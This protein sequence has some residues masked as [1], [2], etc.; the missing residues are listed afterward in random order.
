MDTTGSRLIVFCGKGG[1]GKTT[2]SLAL[3]LHHADCGRKTVVVT[4]HPLPELAVTISLQGLKEQYPI[5]AQNL[6]VV[7]VDAREELANKVRQQIPSAFLARAVLSS[8]I[9]QSLVEVAP[10]LKELSFLAR[11]RQ[12]AERRTDE[13]TADF[14]VLIWDAPAT[15]HFI[16]MLKVARD[17][18]TYLSG[19][20]ALAGRELFQ[21]LATRGNVRLF[22]VTTLEEMAVEETIELC[23]QL[24]GE[25]NLQPAGVICNLASPLLNSPDGDH[26]ELR[27]R[28]LEGNQ[29]S[30][31]LRFIFDRICIERALFR[32]LRAA[33]GVALH[34]VERL[35]GWSS[36]LELLMALAGGAGRSLETSCR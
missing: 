15:G 3:G 27:C 2:L 11:L 22:P 20:F 14:D 31:D 33:I 9:Y 28:M 32:R 16:Q 21:F 23:G 36:D 35:P 29:Q 5:A 1:V 8:R 26:E 4:S 30:A 10:G 18:D 13:R 6:F 34:I 24:S 19:P 12:L 25:L 7:H 17:F